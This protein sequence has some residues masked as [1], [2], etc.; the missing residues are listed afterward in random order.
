[1]VGT[2]VGGPTIFVHE[3][4]GLPALTGYVVSH[5]TRVNLPPRF[6]SYLGRLHRVRK[7]AW[8]LRSALRLV[9]PWPV[10]PAPITVSRLRV[11]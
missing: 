5:F 7:R 11:T 8:S 6:D 3:G 9:G 4:A 1:M 2:P 10:R